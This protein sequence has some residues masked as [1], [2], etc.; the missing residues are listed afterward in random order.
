MEKTRIILADTDYNYLAPLELKFIEELNDEVQLEVI[1]DRDYFKEL[2]SK[3]QNVDILV[4]SEEMYGPELWKHHIACVFVLTEEADTRAER[5]SGIIEL[6]KYT[7]TK[8]I[9]NGILSIAHGILQPSGKKAETTAILVYSPTGG[10]GK[11]TIALGISAALAMQYK[12]VLY[13]DAECM[14]TFQHHV[15]SPV[16]L[17]EGIYRE[18]MYPSADIYERIKSNIQSDRFDYLPPFGF[19]LSSLGISFSVYEELIAATKVSGEYDYI[20][21]DTDSSFDDKKASLMAHVDR[22]L[23]LTGQNRASVYAVNTLMK[24]I[25]HSNMDKYI[26][27]C[28]GFDPQRDNMLESNEIS[29][30]FVVSGYVRHYDN[31]ESSS[32]QETG[33]KADIQK[34]TFLIN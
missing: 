22:I 15:E 26:F 4:V 14:N 5:G 11:T 28:N 19:A 7:S 3:P 32:L 12:K 2:F 13:I 20:I 23:L 9:Y 8:E 34:I 1:T 33:G 27:I 16:F 18:F 29:L 21:I 30:N 24:N 17:S 10:C 6:F 31:L 25:N